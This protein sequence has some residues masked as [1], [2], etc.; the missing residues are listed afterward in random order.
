MFTSFPVS[1]LIATTEGQAGSKEGLQYPV[2]IIGDSSK[3]SV[4]EM[5]LEF[6]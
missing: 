2:T 4:A 3:V 5:T 6:K 1:Q